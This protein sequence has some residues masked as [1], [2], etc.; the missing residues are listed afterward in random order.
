MNTVGAIILA[1]GKGSRMKAKDVNKVAMPLA[2]KPMIIHTIE[3][4]EKMN[5]TNIVVV[6]GFAKESVMKVLGNKVIFAHQ[7]KRLGTAHAVS[8]GLRKIPSGVDHLLVV[9]G[10][11]SAFYTTEIIEGLIEKHFKSR[12]AL[13]F[14]TIERQNPTGLGRIVRDGSG[15]LKAIVEEKDATDEERKITEINPGCYL[16]TTQFLT[17][18]LPKVKKSPVSGEYYITSLIDIGIKNNEE[19]E[20]QKAGNIVWRGVNTKEEL[21]E[22]EQMMNIQAN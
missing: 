4:L 2:D 15:K 7:S 3:R 11:D 13:T 9:N 17:K 12:A 5:I 22:A 14:L 1:A 6:V 16:F 19:I 8:C 10:D 20:T 18:Y 21:Q